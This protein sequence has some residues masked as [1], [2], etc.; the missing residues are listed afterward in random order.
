MDSTRKLAWYK[1]S[2]SNTSSTKQKK[3]AFAPA[4]VGLAAKA[5]NGGPTS[6][7]ETST[8]V[9]PTIP[10]GAPLIRNADG[11]WINDP[12]PHRWDVARR[13]GII[14][15]L[16]ALDAGLGRQYMRPEPTDG[17]FWKAWPDDKNFYS[18]AEFVAKWWKKTPESKQDYWTDK[19][20]GAPSSALRIRLQDPEWLPAKLLGEKQRRQ[21][22]AED[23]E[24]RRIE[25]EERE[26]AAREQREIR[27]E[28]IK[29][30]CDVFERFCALSS[31]TQELIERHIQKANPSLAD[32]VKKR[33][34]ITGKK[35]QPSELNVEKLKRGEI[36]WVDY[37][38]HV[39]YALPEV[40]AETPQIPALA[41]SPP[42]EE[43]DIPPID[44]AEIF[45]RNIT[46]LVSEMKS[47]TLEW[48]EINDR[49][50]FFT[51]DEWGQ[52][53]SEVKLR[54]RG[55]AQAP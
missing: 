23:E 44:A 53:I 34:G 4:V 2:T 5:S 14:Q 10:A 43:M 50:G 36:L 15:K 38:E 55:P 21:R 13:Q 8:A 37:L 19:P 22:R 35:L 40:L 26:A 42:G 3:G 29:V 18:N 20:T 52:I 47:G 33:G 17:R 39:Y 46:R 6:N 51:D 41:C 28:R 7:D 24:R 16:V 54:M 12:E 45:E 11:E 49:Q 30:A 27:A 31:E 32:L 9:S 1:Y 48:D 25:N